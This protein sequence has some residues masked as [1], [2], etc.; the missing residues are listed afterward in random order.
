MRF[1]Y[2]FSLFHTQFASF[3]YIFLIRLEDACW[4]CSAPQEHA[5]NSPV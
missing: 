2:L 4:V 1:F 5:G 3:F